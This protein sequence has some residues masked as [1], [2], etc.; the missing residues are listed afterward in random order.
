MKTSSLASELDQNSYRYQIMIAAR[1]F[2]ANWIEMGEMLTQVASKNAYSEWGYK[3]FEDYCWLELRIKKSTALKL[4]NAWFFLKDEAPQ[5]LNLENESQIPD[6]RSVDVL[7]KAKAEKKWTPEMFAELKDLALEKNR[8]GTTLQKKFKEM[9][10]ALGIDSEETEYKSSSTFL[11]NRL[12]KN[13]NT[14]MCLKNFLNTCQKLKN[15]SGLSP[16][17][18]LRVTVHLPQMM[19]KKTN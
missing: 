10:L 13:W 15:S 11:I 17:T 8:S 9:N 6:L 3:S 7:Q 14:W 18:S 4:T 1:K 16:T 2:K 19:C 5:Y 12:K